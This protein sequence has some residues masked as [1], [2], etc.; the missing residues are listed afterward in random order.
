[1][2]PNILCVYHLQKKHI[3]L[4]RE[5]YNRLCWFYNLKDFHFFRIFSY[6]SYTKKL[7]FSEYFI[8]KNALTINLYLLRIFLGVL[9]MGNI[10]TN[11]IIIC[12]W[13]VVPFL[14][15]ALEL[16]LIKFKSLIECT[17]WYC[18]WHTHMGYNILLRLCFESFFY[19]KLIY[20]LYLCTR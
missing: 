17:F 15:N 4:V 2:Y 1:M 11:C 6:Y 5:I 19:N 12:S 16:C 18:I 3:F 8:Y 14:Y 9:Y 10:R 13:K 7:I 20:V